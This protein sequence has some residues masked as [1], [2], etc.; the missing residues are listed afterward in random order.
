MTNVQR[1]HHLINQTSAPRKVFNALSALAPEIEQPYQM[2]QKLEI[3]IGEVAAVLD[4][5]SLR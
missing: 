4:V 3:G 2:G 1:L 5:S